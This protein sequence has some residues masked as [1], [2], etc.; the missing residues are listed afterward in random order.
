[1]Y[2][3]LEQAL[4]REVALQVLYYSRHPIAEM[5]V[6]HI[7][8]HEQAKRKWEMWIAQHNITDYTIDSKFPTFVLAQRKTKNNHRL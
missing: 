1:M 6:P 3:I 2:S 4:P 7:D 5:M 8:K